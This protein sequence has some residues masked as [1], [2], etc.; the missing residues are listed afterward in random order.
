MA[1][2]PWEKYGGQAQSSGAKPWEK[3]SAFEQAVLPDMP[4]AAAMAMPAYADPD[5]LANIQIEGFTQPVSDPVQ[6][7]VPTVNPLQQAFEAKKVGVGRTA[8]D[9][10]LQGATFGFADEASDVLGAVG[11]KAYGALPFT[12]AVPES[13][14]ELYQNARQMSKEQLAL[15]TEQ[16]PFTSLAANIA[17]GFLTGGAGAGTKVGTQAGNIIRS[18][19][20]ASRVGKGAIAGAA[21][22]GLYGLGSADEGSRLEGAA[23]GAKLGAAFGIAAPIAG[24]GFNKLNTKTVI[25]SSQEVR[26]YAGDLFKKADLEGG[27]I[28]APEANAF[29]DQI[30]RL[31]KQTEVGQAFAGDSLLKKLSQ[32][33]SNSELR[34]K[35]LT[36]Q[37]A[38]EADEAL[39]ELAYSTMNIKGELTSDGQ[40]ALEAQRAL[41]ELVAKT[42]GGETLSK[43][44]E[45]WSASIRMDDIERIMERASRSEQP[46][47]TLRA[48]F[49]TLLNQT[50]K[51][52][53]VNPQEL[54]ALEKA[55][56]T[57]IV[58]DLFRLGGSGLVPIIAGSGGAAATG[59]IGALAA[60]PA[61]AVQQG[62]KKIANARQFSRAENALQSTANRLGLVTKEKRIDFNN[63]FKKPVAEIAAPETGPQ[64]LL[65]A[66]ST[67]FVADDSGSVIPVKDAPA[68]MTKTDRQALADTQ[69]GI[70]AGRKQDQI[71]AAYQ[72]KNDEIDAAYS[73]KD[74]LQSEFK[75]KQ[76][77]SMWSNA[78]GNVQNQIL[79]AVQK[80][81]DLDMELGETTELNEFALKLLQ[82]A[83]KK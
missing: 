75:Q 2:K 53:G 55:A 78:P 21:S 70:K 47:S 57:G 29:Y 1:G 59:G 20:L 80:R 61:Y 16:R 56:Q 37:A 30:G 23:S 15:E 44:R 8:F 11:A 62:S 79:E 7:A 41:R 6:V 49:S 64:L 3:Y 43:A 50:K 69:A 9:Q 24:A 27:I 73:Q 52:K 25:P 13:I 14:P 4:N 76:L 81:A 72:A 54:K 36:F 22:G 38:K 19:N 46:A 63:L 26:Q 58:T 82:A 33:I 10:A 32:R 48:G 17:G 51:I 35:P 66:P 74:R 65:P 34:D 12:Q 77:E 39:G 71:R 83:R 67:R 40:K 28:G 45:A 5:G 18:G 31:D 60:I 42:E 68:F